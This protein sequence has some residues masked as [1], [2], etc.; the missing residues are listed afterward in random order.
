MT[1]RVSWVEGGEEI[2]FIFV[3]SVLFYLCVC[4]VFIV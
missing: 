3:I 2:G 4:E 1:F